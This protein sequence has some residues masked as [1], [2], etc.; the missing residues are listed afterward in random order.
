MKSKVIALVMAILGVCNVYAND[1]Y[2]QQVGS[3]STIDIRQEGSGNQVGDSSTNVYIGSG[4][5]VVNI[6]Q[7]GDNNTLAM[8][9]NGSSADVTLNVIGS[10]NQQTIDCGT[11][12][13]AGC[14]GS[15]INQTI[16]GDTNTITQDLGAGANHTTNL[17]ITGD[18]NTVNQTSTAT[19]TVTSTTTISGSDNKLTH[20]ISG[21]G[22]KTATISITGSTNGSTQQTTEGLT[23]HDGWF[24][25]QSGANAQTVN[26]NSTGS[27]NSVTI[28]QSD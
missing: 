28:R 25:S 21:S 13:A 23:T 12:G 27:G 1:V 2:I 24:I 11:R 8:V 16:T 10:G 3:S 18:T 26:I 15:T 9:V 5:N 7:V 6:D 4:S 14:S 22:T 19:G 17:T 20:L